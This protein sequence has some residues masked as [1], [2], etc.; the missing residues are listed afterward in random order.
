MD[1]GMKEIKV[2]LEGHV[3][4]KIDEMAKRK[5]MSRNNFIKMHLEKLVNLNVFTE[6]RNRFE[7]AINVNTKMLHTF[8]QTEEALKQHIQLVEQLL[9]SHQ[10]K[11]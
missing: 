5:R 7:E 2:R 11:K 6:E 4:K 1:E 8:I 3:V 10:M 9:L